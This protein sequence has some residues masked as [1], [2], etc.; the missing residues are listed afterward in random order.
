MLLITRRS[1]QSIRI[2]EDIVITIRTVRGKQVQVAIEAPLDIIV[3]RTELPPKEIA[4]G[5]EEP[6]HDR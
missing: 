6:A 3:V 2:G 1:G 5:A 4:G